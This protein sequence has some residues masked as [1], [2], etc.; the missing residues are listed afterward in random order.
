MKRHKIFSSFVEIQKH[1]TELILTAVLIALGVNL[2][3]SGVVG[4]FTFEHKEVALIAFGMIISIGVAVRICS[5]KLKNLNRTTNIKG[6]IIY[7]D[8]ERDLIRVPEYDISTDMYRYLH[9][10][11]FENK[12]IEKAWKQDDI[13]QIS[14]VGGTNEGR[15][16]GIASQSGS[17]F[18]ELLEYCV[19]EKLST[20]LRDYFNNHNERIRI[21]EIG[22]T[23]IPEIL[24][25]NRFLRLFS[26]E[27]SNRA[28]FACDGTQ[29]NNEE[30]AGKVVY[31]MNSAGALY[32][33]FD[34]CLPENSKITRK[35]KNEVVI[36]TPI[37]SISISC[38]FGAFGT[39]L[40]SGFYR[41]YLGIDNGQRNYHSY[42]YN[43]EV[44]VK[45]KIGSLFSK[46][47]EF[48]YAWIDSFLDALSNYISQT[49]FF[50][51]I[52]WDTVY[53]IMLCNYNTIKKRS[54][55]DSQPTRQIREMRI[56]ECA[57][58]TLPT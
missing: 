50:N 27:M 9:S 35:S 52:N 1:G 18:I 20:H 16:Q 23:E 12:A 36:D 31:A 44:T 40:K 2:L 49:D 30:K 21:H 15:A 6:F 10:A 19:M 7:D 57:D 5:N 17:L 55:T 8:K 47:K 4:L 37:L 53:T 32:S 24:L 14:I 56:V 42:Q 43:V 38:L 45:Y 58:D 25:S 34:L 3:S 26:E 33:R 11:F 48:Y 39:V 29:D 46:E 22:R 51:K 54:S 13:R 28:A 41:Y